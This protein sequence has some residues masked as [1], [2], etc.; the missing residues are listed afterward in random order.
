MIVVIIFGWVGWDQNF[1]LIRSKTC[2]LVYYYIKIK[3]SLGFGGGHLGRYCSP[4]ANIWCE[5]VTKKVT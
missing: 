5:S 4:A 3:L 2:T 1:K